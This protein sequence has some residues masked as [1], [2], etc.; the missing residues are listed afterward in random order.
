MFIECNK[1]KVVIENYFGKIISYLSYEIFNLHMP[2][3]RINSNFYLTSTSI[4]K[5]IYSK[6]QEVKPIQQQDI[7]V[8]NEV[9]RKNILPNVSKER[10][11]YWHEKEWGGGPTVIDGKTYNFRSSWERI[12]AFYL[13][14]LKEKGVVIEWEYEPEL[15]CFSNIKRGTKAYLPDF[16]VKFRGGRIEYHECK[17]WMDPKSKT[18]I[19]RFYENFPELNLKII[20]KDWFDAFKAGKFKIKGL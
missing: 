5:Q 18:K 10:P 7:V 8:N 11:K 19:K 17:G 6:K 1:Y 3:S 9:V 15:F 16:K 2:A 14:M 4:G 12:Y 20:N 13:Q